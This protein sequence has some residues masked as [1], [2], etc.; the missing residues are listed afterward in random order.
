MS[1][2]KVEM[3]DFKFQQ[4]LASLH[5]LE[6]SLSGS[7]SSSEEANGSPPVSVCNDNGTTWDLTDV[8]GNQDAVIKNKMPDDPMAEPVALQDGSGSLQE[9]LHGCSHDLANTEGPEPVKNMLRTMDL[10]SW[11][12]PEVARKDSTLEPLPSLPL[13]PCSDALSQRSL[14]TSLWDGPST[15]LLQADQSGLLCYPDESAAG[16]APRRAA[17]PLAADRAPSADRPAQR[18]AVVSG[19]HR[20]C[21][22]S[23]PQ[24]ARAPGVCSHWAVPAW[25]VGS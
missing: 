25:L 18:V 24:D 1:F 7:S 15:W 16:M 22:G 12:S 14:D 13:T 23:G 10:S 21:L 2:Q 19:L 11:S 4:T 20:C 8:T 17:S 3:E 6:N 5:V 9:S